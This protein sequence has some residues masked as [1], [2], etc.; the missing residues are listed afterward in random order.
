MTEISSFPPHFAATRQQYSLDETIY[1]Q[2]YDLGRREKIYSCSESD[3][4]R[5]VIK[6]QGWRG[7]WA[8]YGHMY[9]SPQSLITTFS[10]SNCLTA[11]GT[12]IDF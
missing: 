9:T 12:C 1:R 7:Y 4:A 6:S 3:Q 10:Y 5:K 2:K 8:V 11:L